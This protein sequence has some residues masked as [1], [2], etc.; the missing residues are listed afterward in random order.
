MNPPVERGCG[1]QFVQH[2]AQARDNRWQD[3]PDGVMAVASTRELRAR[4][5]AG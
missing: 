4:R 3:R 2:V 1:V 5:D